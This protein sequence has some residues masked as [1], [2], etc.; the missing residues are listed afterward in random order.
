[1]SI[2][3]FALVVIDCPDP[4]ALAPFYCELTGMAQ[5]QDGPTFVVIGTSSDR[6]GIAFQQ[7]AEF[8]P[9]QWPDPAFPQQFHL[10]LTVADLDIAQEQ[11]LALGA[12]LLHDGGP[13]YRVYADPVGHPFC[14]C[15][16]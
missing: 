10:D 7:V 15:A 9:P 14:L 4:W 3:R 13:T 5:L 12:E 11:V 2:A 6:P 1:M 8:R 16:D